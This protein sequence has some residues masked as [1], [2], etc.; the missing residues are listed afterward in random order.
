[1]KIHVR[2]VHIM[3]VVVMARA[4]FGTSLGFHIIYATLGVGLPV[5]IIIA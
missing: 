3:D 5:M 2:C 1:M 4:L